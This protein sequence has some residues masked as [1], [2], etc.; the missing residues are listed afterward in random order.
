[1][2][3]RMKPKTGGRALKA[4]VAK[5]DITPE[6]G[7][8]FLGSG[9]VKAVGTHDPLFARVLVLQDGETR[10]ALVVL[11]L[12]R[13]FQ[14][15]LID[16]LERR[17]RSSRGV[18][19]LL[20]SATHTHSGPIIPLN[21]EYPLKGMA[22]WQVKAV[23]KVAAA[24]EEACDRVVSAALGTGYGVAHIGHNRR[25]SDGA[26]G[27]R[28]M[29]SNP[30]MEPT[31]PLDPTVTVVRVNT[32]RGRP[33]AILVNYACHPV[34]VM[35]NLAQYSADFPGVMT[36]V[37]E[38]AF[39]QQPLCFFL[40]GA[41]ADIDTYH[42][43]VPR[44][45]DPVKWTIWSGERL[46]TEA[47]RVAEGISP[48]KAPTPGLSYVKDRPS[49]RWR[50][51]AGEFEK[52]MRGVNPPALLEFYMPLIK[53]H[54]ELPSTTILIDRRLA[55][56]SMPGEAFVESQMEWRT[57]C[58]VEHSLFAGCANGFFSYLPTIRAAAEGGH[59]GAFWTR[60]EPGVAE[61][62]VDNAV[63]RT[64]EMLGRLTSAPTPVRVHAPG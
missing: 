26:G 57:R 55:L 38:E 7:L 45:A 44:E 12:C 59:G 24:I 18:S 15:P 9:D 46:G 22:A 5:V 61:R 58:P 37:V 62:L 4:G 31:S 10:L 36:R 48:E 41:G 19:C 40:Q 14:A 13:V 32:L 11:D 50:W 6:P 16:R 8:Y 25:R 56:M 1:M 28:M 23:E 29:W 30:T 64:Y 3:N 43:N 21:E 33:L 53:R 2:T 20:V 49:F 63:I 35:G 52:A 34:V 42:T 47:A 54:L 27:V 39:D 17:V 51:A 60:V